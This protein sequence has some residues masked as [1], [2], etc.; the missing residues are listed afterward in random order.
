VSQ[1]LCDAEDA[2]DWQIEG[3]VDIDRSR[4]EGRPVIRVERIGAE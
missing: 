1:I 4:A 2:N 3:Y